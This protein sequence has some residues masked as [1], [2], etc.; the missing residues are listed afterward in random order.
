M[1]SKQ[2]PKTHM[3][4]ALKSSSSSCLK[5]SQICSRLKLIPNLNEEGKS[6]A[7]F[8]K[9]RLGK[10]EGNQNCLGSCRFK[11]L[12][13]IFLLTM[14][15][16]F[17]RACDLPQ[18]LRLVGIEKFNWLVKLE[19]SITLV[20][21]LWI[22]IA[23][24]IVLRLIKYHQRISNLIKRQLTKIFNL[25]Y[26]KFSTRFT[27]QRKSSLQPKPNGEAWVQA[28]EKKRQLISLT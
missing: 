21:T 22:N 8:R 25:F 24:S 7:A 23:P 27:V 19:A 2:K 4:I 26:W 18:L 1:S 6:N 5:Y 14:K 11:P 12:V 3:R 28:L 15:R 13:T 10:R 17:N 20:I 16:T 9:R